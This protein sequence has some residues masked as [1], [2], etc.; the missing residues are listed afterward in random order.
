MTDRGQDDEESHVQG[1]R[2]LALVSDIVGIVLIVAAAG[3][4]VDLL[5]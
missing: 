5:L 1:S 3:L 4:L 2:W